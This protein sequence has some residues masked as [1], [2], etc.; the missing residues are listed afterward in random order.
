MAEFLERRKSKR[1]NRQLV[2]SVI[3]KSKQEGRDILVEEYAF[4]EDIGAGGVRI[5]LPEQLPKDKPVDLKLFL[6]SDPIPLPARGR[7]VWSKVK[8]RFEI[9]L[10]AAPKFDSGKKY[11]IGIQFVEIDPVTQERIIRMIKEDFFEE[12]K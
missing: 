6:F 4:I 5:I 8:Q 9:K 11:W 1:I 2:I 3:Y 7:A 12:D 10:N